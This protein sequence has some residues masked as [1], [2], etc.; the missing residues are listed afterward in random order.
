LHGIVKQNHGFVWAYSEVGMGAV[1]KIYLPGVRVAWRPLKWQMQTRRPY[2]A[3]QRPFFWLKMR[4]LCAR[5]A[6][7]F[8]AFAVTPCC[9][10]KMGRTRCLSRKITEMRLTWPSPTWGCLALVKVN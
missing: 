9:K 3:G 4:T 2:L 5:Q 1:F 10:Q 6:P 8:S 7:N